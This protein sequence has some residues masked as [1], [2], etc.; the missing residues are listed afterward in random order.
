MDV[1]TL[2]YNAPWWLQVL[3]LL[4]VVLPHLRALVPV[5][6][7]GPFVIV[8]KILDVIVGNY[9]HAK[10]RGPAAP[11][12]APPVVVDEQDKVTPKPE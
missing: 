10:N 3:V 1:L 2:A 11:P 9:G 6:Y 12:V 7:K 8:L 4:T 5:P